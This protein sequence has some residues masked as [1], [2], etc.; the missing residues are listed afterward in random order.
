MYTTYIQYTPVT[1]EFWHCKSF[2]HQ[3]LQYSFSCV[4]P[5]PCGSGNGGCSHLCLLSSDPN[6]YSCACP[7]GWVLQGNQSCIPGMLFIMME[8]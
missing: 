3:F 5:N 8:V 1:T 6:G 2:E 4:A 7:D